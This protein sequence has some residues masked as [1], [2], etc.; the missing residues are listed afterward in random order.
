MMTLESYL[1]VAYLWMAEQQEGFNPYEET[2]DIRALQAEINYQS[3]GSPMAR[4]T[5]S[6]VSNAGWVDYADM[7]SAVAKVED[8]TRHEVKFDKEAYQQGLTQEQKVI[9]DRTKSK[10]LPP[11]RR[12]KFF[13]PK[14][15]RS[16][17]SKIKGLFYRESQ[18]EIANEYQNIAGQRVKSGKK[19]TQL[20]I[21][22]HYQ[23]F[24]YQQ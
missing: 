10:V 12:Y 18:D 13:L 5:T 14:E 3:D 11:Q 24:G 19:V 4:G 9:I 1:N 21:Q 17:G 20:Q 6:N 23:D 22:R 7:Q 8:E 15:V 16:V 2:T